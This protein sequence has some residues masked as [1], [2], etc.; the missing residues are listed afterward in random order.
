[1]KIIFENLKPASGKR[2]SVKAFEAKNINLSVTTLRHN[3]DLIKLSSEKLFAFYETDL[4]FNN[5]QYMDSIRDEAAFLFTQINTL[6]I[7]DIHGD[8]LLTKKIIDD[9][10]KSR[11]IEFIALEFFRTQNPNM[12][13]MGRVCLRQI[14][15]IQFTRMVF[16]YSTDETNI[17]D[18]LDI[19]ISCGGEIY[20]YGCLVPSTALTELIFED[21]KMINM[22]VRRLA[23][24]F[25]RL[26]SLHIRP[27]TI[28]SER[29]VILSYDSFHSMNNMRV[30]K[31]DKVAV[32]SF[33][34][35]DGGCMPYLEELYVRF[36]DD[37]D[38]LTHIESFPNFPK[39]TKLRLHLNGV[40]YIHPKAFDHLT[41]LVLFEISC[42]DLVGETFETGVA[43]HSMSFCVTCKVLVLHFKF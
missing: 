40:K 21:C 37:L 20:A 7:K 30:L 23:E 3:M 39:L 2:I 5:F 6:R 41:P 1:M 42:T 33:E 9:F 16:D 43:A 28:I 14:N 31:L 27:A 35:L 12:L 29:P 22:D 34:M 25:P 32:Q 36:A 11:K 13:L 17:S 4:N 26:E 15:K 38:S 10:Q 18:S 8:I 24:I 19:F